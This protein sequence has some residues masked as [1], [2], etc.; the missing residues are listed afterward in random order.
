MEIC[1]AWSQ[2]ELLFCQPWSYV[3]VGVVLL[4][5]WNTHMAERYLVGD[6]AVTLGRY[7]KQTVCAFIWVNGALLEDGLSVALLKEHES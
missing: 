4:D 7:L 3:Y 6:G 1:I 2:F 5:A